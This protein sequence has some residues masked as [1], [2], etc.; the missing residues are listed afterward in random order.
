MLDAHCILDPKAIYCA[1]DDCIACG[2]RVASLILAI[3]GS[4]PALGPWPRC[5]VSIALRAMGSSRARLI[6]SA[7]VRQPA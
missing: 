3:I 7:D 4:Y 6:L 5:I 1:Q 2:R